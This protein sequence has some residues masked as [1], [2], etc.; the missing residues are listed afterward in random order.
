M[1]PLPAVPN[2][3]KLR[4]TW[5]VDSDL[6]AVSIMH[7]LYSGTAPTDSSMA[8]M[9]ATI[10]SR[11]SV[12]FVGLAFSTVVFERIDLE[13]LST[14]S[15]AIGSATGT[16]A[17]TRTGFRLPANAATLINFQIA[18]RYR[19]GKPRQYWPLGAESD[20]QTQQQWTAG[21][22]AGVDSTFVEYF[23]HLLGAGA[24]GTTITNVV[25]VSYYS[26][27]TPV[28]NPITGRTRDVPK[29]RTGSIPVDIV[30]GA[31]TNLKVGS[32]RRRT[33]IRS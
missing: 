10:Y 32:Q 11:W 22:K 8:T 2:V 6:T 13:D 18:R 27:F 24:G 30:L 1:P 3:I 19:G 21:Y 12:D 25:S 29:V 4:H 23:G 16:V 5:A 33:L 31:S 28:T 9:A 7:L 14:S 20:L 17:G 26:G 15:G